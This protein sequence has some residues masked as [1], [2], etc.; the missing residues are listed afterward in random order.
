[1]YFQS[2]QGVSKLLGK[3]DFHM[4]IWILLEKSTII[5]SN[6][7]LTAISSID[8]FEYSIRLIPSPIITSLGS[9][10]TYSGSQLTIPYAY[11]KR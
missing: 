10:F 3:S 6:M 9:I 5:S 7:G 2:N 11:W 1:M 4:K 8:Y